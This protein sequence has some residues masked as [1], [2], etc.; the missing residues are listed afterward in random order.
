MTMLNISN[1]RFT[2]LPKVV[3]NISGLTHLDLSSNQ[4]RSL[5]ELSKLTSLQE[6]TCNNNQ[7]TDFPFWVWQHNQ[8]RVLSL[9]FNQLSQIADFVPS[10]VS[11]LHTLRL[12]NNQLVSITSC[13][14]NHPSLEQ[15]DISFNQL[16]EQPS[17]MEQTTVTTL[18]TA[19][20]PFSKE[21]SNESPLVQLLQAKGEATADDLERI[22]PQ[23]SNDKSELMALYI[24]TCLFQEKTPEEIAATINKLIS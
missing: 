14:A 15:L 18:K 9:Q 20:N 19:G 16:A 13:L 17:W 6:V 8:L 2:D 12:S 5:P 4:L 7:L 10:P 23:L 3:E 22:F 11:L 21:S 1:N 24:R